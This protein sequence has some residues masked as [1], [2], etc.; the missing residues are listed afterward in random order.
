MT[1]QNQKQNKAKSKVITEADTRK[2]AAYAT[3]FPFDA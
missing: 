1:L 2:G 3:P